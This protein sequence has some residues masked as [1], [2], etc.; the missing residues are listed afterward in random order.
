MTLLMSSR[1]PSL[2]SGTRMLGPRVEGRVAAKGDAG[3]RGTRVNIRRERRKKVVQEEDEGPEREEVVRVDEEEDNGEPV[4]YDEDFDL[5]QPALMGVLA[6]EEVVGVHS[7]INFDRHLRVVE[8][9]CLQRDA[10]MKYL[11]GTVVPHFAEI[12]DTN[13][14]LEGE[15]TGFKASIELVGKELKSYKAQNESLKTVKVKAEKSNIGLRTELKKSRE[16]LAVRTAEVEAEKKEAD[17]LRAEIERVQK[18]RNPSSGMGK[19]EV[20]ALIKKNLACH[21]AKWEEEKAKLVALGA[22]LV[23]ESFENAVAQIKLK[24][25]GLN[26]D[27]MSLE[28]EVFRGHIFRVDIEARKLYDVDTGDEVADWDE[29]GEYIKGN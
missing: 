17:D 24:N 26:L 29:D 9:Q 7:R 16:D 13:E 6:N 23:K 25:P 27:E 20:T 15:V 10:F 2:R 11:R 18:V 12:R 1:P 5:D 4:L 8:Q 22:N 28:F 14:N 21:Q 3:A 19:Q